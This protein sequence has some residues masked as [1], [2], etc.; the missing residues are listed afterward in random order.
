MRFAKIGG[1]IL[2]FGAVIVVVFAALTL[3]VQFLWNAV[4]ADVFGAP[5]LSFWQAGLL[6]LL[7]STVR[8]IIIAPNIKR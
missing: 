7:V 6:L 8:N 3:W 1:A 2:G 5:A 4:A